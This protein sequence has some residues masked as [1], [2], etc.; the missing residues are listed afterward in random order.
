MLKEN[1]HDAESNFRL[2]VDQKNGHL[3]T[4]HVFQHVPVNCF[5]ESHER[6]TW[7]AGWWRRGASD[8]EAA[9]RS[10][11]VRTPSFAINFSF[12]QHLAL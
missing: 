12:C 8:A 11:C 7:S 3:A 5:A 9:L 6:P 10:P 4:P 2:S 1:G